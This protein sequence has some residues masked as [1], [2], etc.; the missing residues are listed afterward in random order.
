MS[1][2]IYM[3]IY[4]YIYNFFPGT[5]M[6]ITITYVILPTYKKSKTFSTDIK[7]LFI[8]KY[9]SLASYDSTKLL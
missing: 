9:Y 2:Y 8:V 6:I 5:T 1:I 3:Y 7:L 4:I